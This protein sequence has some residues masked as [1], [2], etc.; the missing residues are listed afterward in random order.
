MPVRHVIALSD[1]DPATGLVVAPE[2]ARHAVITAGRLASLSG[3]V[4]VLTHL[5]LD[6]P[7]HLMHLCVVAE[8]LEVGAAVLRDGDGLRLAPVAPACFQRRGRVDIGSRRA[9]WVAAVATARA[10]RMAA[11]G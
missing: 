8:T 3:P 10:E 5:N 11:R 6:A 1:L 7:E 9:A 2:R 4:D